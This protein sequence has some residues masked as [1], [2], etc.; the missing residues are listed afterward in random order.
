MDAHQLIKRGESEKIEFKEFLKLKDEIGKAVS[1]FSNCKGGIILVGVADSG[2]VIGFSVGKDALEELANYIKRNTDPQIY[3]SLKVEEADGKKVIAIKV[4]ESEEKPVFFKNHAYKRV[5]R[6][7]HLI[8]SS[9]IRKLAK[10][11]KKKLNWDEQVCGDAKLEDID[12][13]KAEDFLRKTKNERNFYIQPKTPLKEVLGRLELMRNGKLTNA[14]AL[15]FGKNPQK[16]FLQAETRCARFKGTEPLKFIDMKVFEGTIID[17]IGKALNFTLEH[18][19]MAAWIEP[20]R[21]ERKEK[22]EYPPEAIREA[23]INAV[24][25]RDYSISSNI[26]IRIFDDKIEIWGCGP[27]PMP[28]TLE[29]LKRKH[30]SILRNPLIGKCFFLIGYIE[31]WGTGTNKIIKECLNHGIPEPLFEEIAQ[32]LVVTFRKSKLTKEYLDIL[33]LNERQKKTIE[34]LKE[35]N[36]ITKGGHMKLNDISKTPAFE[37]INDLLR[38]KLIAKKGIGRNTYYILE[39]SASK[40]PK[41][42]RKIIG[43]LLMI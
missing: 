13:E 2:K 16:F 26:Q 43:N 10:E 30:K 15:L 14:A 32:N 6:S 38:K 41:K 21:P 8:S 27:L 33:G 18:M 19:P 39:E 28:L 36:K 17:Q 1:S 9:E 23:I 7:D 29:D 42:D 5:G 35:H 20:G 22:Y 24:C 40:R 3:P 37:D 25:H 12:E 4:N 34:Y 11:E 31:Q